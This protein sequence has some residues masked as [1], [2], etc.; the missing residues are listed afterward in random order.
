MQVRTVWGALL[1]LAGVAL[2]ACGPGGDQHPPPGT[3]TVAF[4]PVAPSV[5][6]LTL[7][8]AIVKLD[9]IQPIGNGPPPMPPMPPRLLL[10]A[11]S[12]TGA[13]FTFDHVPPGVY[14]RV[15]FTVDDVDVQ[16]SWRGTPFVAHLAPFGGSQIDLRASVGVAIEPGQDA[17]LPVR[18]DPSAWFGGNVLDGATPAAGQITVDMT[19]NAAVAGTML[20]RLEGSFFLP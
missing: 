18:V 15:Q 16:G 5:A 3:L 8:S 7:T 20:M 1:V 19:D 11:L 6:E 13:S 4:G 12:A 14:S 17:T 2:G 9:R 10:D